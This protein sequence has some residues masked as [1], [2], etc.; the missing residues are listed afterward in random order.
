MPG[1]VAVLIE[2]YFD[3]VEYRRFNEYFPALGLEVV[4]VSHL[5]G[6]P[7]LTF[8]SVPDQTKRT[9]QVVVSTEIATADPAAY[10]GILLIADYAMDRMRYQAVVRKGQPNQAPAVEFLR[11]AMRAG[12]VTGALCHGL[13]LACAAPETIRGRRVTCG[14]N[15]ICDVENAGAEVVYDG[16]RTADLVT[17][18]NLLTGRSPEI[19][20]A[21]LAAFTAAITR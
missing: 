17:D 3:P 21:Y 5:W 19:L 9:E 1:Q 12:T 16:D 18:G 7:S 11:R 10:R 6:Q 20:D 13:W 15:I 8:T 4:Y 2:E 14:H